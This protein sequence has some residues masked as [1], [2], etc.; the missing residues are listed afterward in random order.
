[1]S[2]S[3]YNSYQEKKT[4]YTEHFKH[5]SYVLWWQL[6][7]CYHHQVDM[8]LPPVKQYNEQFQSNHLYSVNGGT[9]EIND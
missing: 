6:D 5:L 3:N 9:Y 1:M 7:M 4:K 8:W 2:I